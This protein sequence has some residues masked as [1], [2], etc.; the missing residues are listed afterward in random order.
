MSKK[1]GKITA[2]RAKR[3]ERM[4]LS[5]EECIKRMLSFPE[6]REAIIATIRKGKNRRVSS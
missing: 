3:P 2:K 5:A 6:R 1:N 4:K